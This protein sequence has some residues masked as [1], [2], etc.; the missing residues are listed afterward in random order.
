[1]YTVV[2]VGRRTR[3]Q[4]RHFNTVYRDRLVKLGRSI[5]IL[6]CRDVSTVMEPRFGNF[7]QNLQSYVTRSPG[8]ALYG[9][10]S[11]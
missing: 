5:I 2:C 9:V 7:E 6:I 1:M 3:G 10:P 4:G 11:C 8:F